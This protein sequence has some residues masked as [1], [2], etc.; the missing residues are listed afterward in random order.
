MNILHTAVWACLLMGIVAAVWDLVTRTVPNELTLGGIAVGFSI[1]V[2]AGF[3]DGGWRG[4]SGGFIDSLL[5][6]VVCSLVPVISFARG[7]M[8]GGDVKLFAAIGALCGPS[9]G[10]DAQ[11]CT[12]LIA[13]SIVLPWRLL[14]HGAIG[15]TARNASVVVRN[16]FYR[17]SQRLPL[18]CVKLP[19]VVMAPT[20]LVGLCL[21][22]LRRGILS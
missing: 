3:V 22:I 4:A 18:V 6:I 2:A 8:G 12:F 7:E 21:A 5:G 13:M 19:P 15:A 17:G 20:I 16:T 11:A 9:L 10:F 1:H 14:R